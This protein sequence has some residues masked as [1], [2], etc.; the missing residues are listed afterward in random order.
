MKLTHRPPAWP[1]HLP[2]RPAAPLRHLG[3]AAPRP[4]QSPPGTADLRDPPRADRQAQDCRAL[5]QLACQ[6]RP[7]PGRLPSARPRHLPAGLPHPARRGPALPHLGTPLPRPRT[8]HPASAPP[9]HDGPARPGPAVGTG[10]SPAARRRPRPRRPRRRA[11][12]PA[13]RPAPRPHRPP[14]HQPHQPRRRAHHADARHHANQ[15]PRT[16]RQPPA[17][18]HLPPPPPQPGP[19]QRTRAMA[20]P[21]PAPRAARPARHHQPPAGPHRRQH[22]HRPRQRAP[23]ARRLPPTVVADLLGLRPKTAIAWGQ[24][25]GCPGPPTPPCATSAPSRTTSVSWQGGRS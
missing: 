2:G 23:A 18:P 5:H 4:R 8:H 21:R 16:P 14:H 15:H 20:V 24:L 7:G 22:G 17:R 19:R 9:G 1:R 13:V 12:R 6:P 25:A 3:T 10:R 11:A